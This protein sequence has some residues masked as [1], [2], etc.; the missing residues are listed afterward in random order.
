MKGD[1]NGGEDLDSE[2]NADSVTLI[3]DDAV[4]H[5]QPF[6]VLVGN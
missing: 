3:D 2:R 5:C 4:S 1:A 6:A